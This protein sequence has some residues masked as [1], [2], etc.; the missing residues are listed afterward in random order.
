[1][2]SRPEEFELG[3]PGARAGVGRLSRHSSAH[4]VIDK[5]IQIHGGMGIANETGL[6]DALCL[7]RVTQIAEG[8]SEIQLRSIAQQLL[9]GRLDMTFQ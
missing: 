1:M 7:A 5:C 9:R 4:E 3:Q 8:S 6:F 2:R